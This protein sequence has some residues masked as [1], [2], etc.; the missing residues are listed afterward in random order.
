MVILCSYCLQ[1]EAKWTR[2]AIEFFNEA[3][4]QGGSQ[5]IS[6]AAGSTQQDDGAV[7]NLQG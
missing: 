7:S 2:N 3:A 1:H 4:A 6:T 5:L